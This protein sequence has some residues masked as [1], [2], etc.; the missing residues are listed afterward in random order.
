M[1]SV[2]IPT[3]YFE[4]TAGRL[5]EDPAGFLRADWSNKKRG[6]EDARALFTHMT[7]AL[8]RY[9]WSKILI[10]QVGMQPFSPQE[11][12]WAAQEWLPRIVREGGYRFGAILVSQDVMTRLATAYITTQVQKLPLVYRSFDDEAAA[13]QWLLQQRS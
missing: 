5:L 8:Q 13:V 6:P 2:G 11:Q 1:K 10:N 12:E 7:R 3:L 9:G 4:N